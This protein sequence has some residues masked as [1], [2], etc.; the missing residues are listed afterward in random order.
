M[1]FTHAD[2]ADSLKLN[3]ILWQNAMGNAPIPPQLLVKHRK[4]KKDDDDD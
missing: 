3:I 4:P 2:R 1:D